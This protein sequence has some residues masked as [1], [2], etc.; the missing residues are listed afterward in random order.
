MRTMYCKIRLNTNVSFSPSLSSNLN[1]CFPPGTVEISLRSPILVV[2]WTN[3]LTKYAQSRSFPQGSGE[4]WKNWNHL[5]FHLRIIGTLA[6]K[7]TPHPLAKS[8]PR[9]E[10]EGRCLGIQGF[11]KF[12]WPSHGIKKTTQIGWYHQIAWSGLYLLNMNSCFFVVCFPIFGHVICTKN[13]I[14]FESAWI[15]K[16]FGVSM[17]KRATKFQHNFMGLRNSLP[18]S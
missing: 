14:Y 17:L 15:T 2:G 18:T 5:V 7:Q 12:G 11:D 13:D 10:V 9:P 4:N 3:H 8:I 6:Y 16:V 1:W